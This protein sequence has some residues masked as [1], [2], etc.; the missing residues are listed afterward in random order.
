VRRSAVNALTPWQTS[1]ENNPLAVEP[2]DAS[3]VAS[4]EG[5]MWRQLEGF[6]HRVDERLPHVVI[7]AALVAAATALITLIDRFVF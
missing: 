1:S 4:H 2:G 7:D 6:L 5:S 3:A